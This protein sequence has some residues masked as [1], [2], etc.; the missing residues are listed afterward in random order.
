MA[1]R[2]KE[3]TFRLH[4]VMFRYDT[5][6]KAM[7]IRLY[8]GTTLL[9]QKIYPYGAHDIVGIFVKIAAYIGGGSI[10]EKEIYGPTG[11]GVG[12]L[13]EI[14]KRALKERA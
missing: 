13:Y 3:I 10:T 8:D 14:Y 9:G 6:S 11:N 2:S 5:V 12:G 4:R 1:Y 7:G